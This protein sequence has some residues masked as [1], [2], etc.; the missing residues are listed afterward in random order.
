A[1][2]PRLI[3][4]RTNLYVPGYGQGIMGDTGG[5]RLSRYWI[6]LG[7]SDEDFVNWYRYT[8]VYLLTPVPADVT[9]LLPAWSS[10]HPN[11][12]DD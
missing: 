12:R 6:D 7:Y 11:I 3:P 10:P 2:D 9:Y 8:D 1:A 4:Y 5:A